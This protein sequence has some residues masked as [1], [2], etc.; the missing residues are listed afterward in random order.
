MICEVALEKESFLSCLQEENLMA[1]AL[2]GKWDKLIL[3]LCSFISSALS[4]NHS[5]L[6]FITQDALALFK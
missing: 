1:I 3:A 6:K 4:D 2:R 5:I